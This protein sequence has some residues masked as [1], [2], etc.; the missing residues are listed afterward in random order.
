MSGE[1]CWMAELKPRATG[2]YSK[3]FFRTERRM[4]RLK[5]TLSTACV[6][7]HNVLTAKTLQK[8]SNAQHPVLL[9]MVPLYTLKSNI[10]SIIHR[11]PDS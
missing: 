9:S 10:L 1:S 8:S 4:K 11:W 2:E 3:C 6:F 5:T 7:H